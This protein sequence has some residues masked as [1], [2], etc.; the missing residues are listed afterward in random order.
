VK[1]IVAPIHLKPHPTNEH[2]MVGEVGGHQVI[3][4]NHYDEGTLGFF[5]PDG[6]IIPDKLAEEMWVKGK[7]SGK[8]K[9]R[10]KA[11]TMQGVQS[12]GLFY[13]SRYWTIQDGERVYV[14]SAS[15]NSD[16]IVGQD[17]SQ[18]VGIQ[19]AGS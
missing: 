19:Y 14:D 7:L 8:Q 13:G 18:E 15:W 6:A 12:E 9:N 17:V 4:G 3:V 2:L 11:R 16:W 5:I 1:T 10:V